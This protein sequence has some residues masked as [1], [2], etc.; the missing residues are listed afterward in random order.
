MLDGWTVSPSHP[1]M[2][3]GREWG[4]EGSPQRKGR[5]ALL[6]AR[7]VHMDHHEV[8]YDLLH[9]LKVEE[10]VEARMIWG[11]MGLGRQKKG[12]SG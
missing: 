8:L 6:H 5:G 10:G 3:V 11:G 4:L 12:V 9:V 1:A 2:R 7:R